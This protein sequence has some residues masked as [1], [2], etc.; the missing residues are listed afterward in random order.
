M[1]NNNMNTKIN[2][3]QKFDLVVFSRDIIEIRK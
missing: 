3:I 2:N 1:S